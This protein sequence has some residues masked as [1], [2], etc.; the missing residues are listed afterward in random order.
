M[1]YCVEIPIAII[2]RKSSKDSQEYTFPVIS[3]LPVSSCWSGQYISLPEPT[4]YWHGLLFK[5]NRQRLTWSRCCNWTCSS[6][7][8]CCSC[9]LSF[10][11]LYSSCSR[12]SST[13]SSSCCRLQSCFTSSSKHLSSSSFSLCSFF[14]LTVLRAVET[15]PYSHALNSS[16][17]ISGIGSVCTAPSTVVLADSGAPVNLGHQQALA[18]FSVPLSHTRTH[19]RLFK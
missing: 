4:R 14:H 3:S 12:C 10:L 6:C 18:L 17:A 13:C 9:R 8:R 19:M 7:S 5:G 1:Y 16:G 11:V 2:G 15:R